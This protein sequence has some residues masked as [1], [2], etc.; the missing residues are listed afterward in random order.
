MRRILDAGLH[1]ELDA[2][3]RASYGARAGEAEDGNVKVPPPGR[4]LLCIHD[5]QDVADT[6]AG[7]DW[8]REVT[9]RTDSERFGAPR[10]C[11]FGKERRPGGSNFTL[12][13]SEAC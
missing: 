4:F 10:E 6:V 1:K 9:S 3:L 11:T 12:R 13:L 2:S 8:I 5:V 7:F